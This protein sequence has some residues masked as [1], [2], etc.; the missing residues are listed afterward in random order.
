[1]PDLQFY[2]QTYQESMNDYDLAMQEE[3]LNIQRAEANG[4]T[5]AARTASQNLAAL[6]VQR[7]EYVAMSNQHA[8]S[9]RPAPGAS[10]WGLSKDEQEIA[11]GISGGDP[12]LSKEDR[13]KIYLENKNKLRH[14][15]QTGEYRDDQGRASR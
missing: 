8:E 15:R 5:L 1:M 11:H 14:M 10:R 9:L 12:R 6:R 7:S 2:H 13:E 3:G 4:D